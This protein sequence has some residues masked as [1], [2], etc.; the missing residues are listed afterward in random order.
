MENRVL[1]L[2]IVSK[3]YTHAIFADFTGPAVIG[4]VLQDAKGQWILRFSCRIGV[5]RSDEAELQAVLDGLKLCKER[6]YTRVIVELDSRDVHPMIISGDYSRRRML[7][8]LSADVKTFMDQGMKITHICRE[9]TLI[10]NLTIERALK[11]S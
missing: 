5:A 3:L 8:D 10:A 2:S 11:L 9:G 4:G 6:G 1:I 7:V